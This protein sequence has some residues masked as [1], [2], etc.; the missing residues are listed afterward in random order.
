MIEAGGGTLNSVA[1]ASGLSADAVLGIDDVSTGS[2]LTFGQSFA[3][4]PAVGIATQSAMDG[5]NGGWA[6][7]PAGG[8]LNASQM[9]ISVDEDQLSDSERAHTSEQ[10]SYIVFGQDISLSH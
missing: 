7:F 8:G 10:V 6:V 9:M 4:A 3:S 2:A 1:Y 5:N